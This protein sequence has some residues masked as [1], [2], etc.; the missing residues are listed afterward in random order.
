[1]LNLLT[2]YTYNDP[3]PCPW[4]GLSPRWNHW[5]TNSEKRIF[6]HHWIFFIGSFPSGENS[7]AFVCFASQLQRCWK[8]PGLSPPW[9]TCL[10]EPMGGFTLLLHGFPC[11]EFH[12]PLPSRGLL[13]AQQHADLKAEVQ[14][15]WCYTRGYILTHS[16]L[17]PT[18]TC[19]ITKLMC[20]LFFW[21]LGSSAIAG[22]LKSS[23]VMLVGKDPSWKASEASGSCACAKG[24]PGPT[25][26]GP[27]SI[28]ASWRD[29]TSRELTPRTSLEMIATSFNWLRCYRLLAMS[30]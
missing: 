5:N 14:A 25:I 24:Q 19:K 8:L 10:K 27:V 16:S 30:F 2:N 26:H 23:K 22:I 18:P 11:L 3:V 29:L 9:P 12:S 28:P 17:F 20:N 4:G 13:N 15:P 1:M 7:S 21:L 6:Q